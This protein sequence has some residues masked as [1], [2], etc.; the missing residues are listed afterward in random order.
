[1]DFVTVNKAISAIEGA[2]VDNPAKDEQKAYNSGI[3]AAGWALEQMVP[4]LTGKDIGLM[5]WAL[6]V[7]RDIVEEYGPN[8]GGDWTVE[9]IE[10]TMNKIQELY[11]REMQNDNPGL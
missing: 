4:D 6:E 11:K 10:K 8:A 5:S 7:A 3:T 1:M 2:K 9:D